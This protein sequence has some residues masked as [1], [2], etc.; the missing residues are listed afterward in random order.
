M[1]KISSSPLHFPG[2]PVVGIRLGASFHNTGEF[3]V[4]E[5]AVV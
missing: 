1:F 3:V 2:P 4:V 5:S